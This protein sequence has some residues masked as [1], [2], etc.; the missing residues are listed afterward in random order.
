M[1]AAA[2]RRHAWFVTAFSWWGCSWACRSSPPHRVH[3]L[4]SA[5]LL[6]RASDEGFGPQAVVVAA[7]AVAAAHRLHRLP[8]VAADVLPDVGPHE[9]PPGAGCVQFRGFVGVTDDQ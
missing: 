7:A 4:L 9:V 3:L 8:V 6:D 1:V 5:A 2:V